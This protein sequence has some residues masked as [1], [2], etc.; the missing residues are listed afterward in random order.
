M[1]NKRFILSFLLCI[2]PIHALAIG[3]LMLSVKQRAAI[4]VARENGVTD[5]GDEVPLDEVRMNGF[6]FNNNDKQEKGVVWVNGKQVSKQAVVNGVRLK[7]VN[8]RDKIISLTLEKT[9]SSIPIKA[10]QTLLLN[11]GQIKESFEK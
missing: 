10:G 11:D 7:K 4:D 2:Q 8:E 6:F 1:K 3:D 5:V 9:Q